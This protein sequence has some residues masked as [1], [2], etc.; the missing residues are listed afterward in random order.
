MSQPSPS[1]ITLTFIFE[2]SNLRTLESSNPRTLTQSAN[3]APRKRNWSTHEKNVGFVAVFC[4]SLCLSWCL[5]AVFSRCVFLWILSAFLGQRVVVYPD[6]SIEVTGLFALVCLYFVLFFFC[7]RDGD[8]HSGQ[9]NL[10]LILSQILTL[11]LTLTVKL[12]LT[13]D[14]VNRAVLKAWRD[15]LEVPPLP[16]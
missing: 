11:P 8:W 14:H 2:P 13:L 5:F 3:A 7:R 9:V 15:H 10:I 4:L 1:P 6:A 16:L 12:G